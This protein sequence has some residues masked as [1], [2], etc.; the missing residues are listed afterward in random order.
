M[1]QNLQVI[2]QNKTKKGNCFQ[3]RISGAWC[4]VKEVIKH[5][6]RL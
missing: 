1:I 3:Y 5:L 4:S 2:K 6:I